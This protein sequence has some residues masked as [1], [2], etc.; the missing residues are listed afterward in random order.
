MTSYKKT[1]SDTPV[2]PDGQVPVREGS[3]GIAREKVVSKLRQVHDAEQKLA[4]EIQ[5]RAAQ[6]EGLRAAG[7]AIQ[8]E[9]DSGLNE[10]AQV[11]KDLIFYNGSLQA[12]QERLI[13]LQTWI[14]RHFSDSPTHEQFSELYRHEKMAAWLPGIITKTQSR[15]A[16][17]D[18]T[19]AELA[20]LNDLEV[21]V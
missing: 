12:A 17:L 4:A 18:K 19:I 1:Y 20:R 7:I 15:L 5:Q 6:L 14:E 11:R 8:D 13:E 10:R 16:D 9:W 2:L 21:P 3:P